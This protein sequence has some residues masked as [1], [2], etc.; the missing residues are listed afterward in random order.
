VLSVNS[1][2][3]DYIDQCRR[4]VD[5]EVAAYEAL[6]SASGK[7]GAAAKRVQ[8]AVADFEPKF[9]NSMVLVLDALVVHR[10]RT[11]EGKDGN[12]L[13]EVR[14]LCRSIMENGGVLMADKQIKLKADASVLKLEVGDEISLTAS[15][16]RLICDAYFAELEAR[17]L[18]A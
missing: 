9:F 13:N 4:L 12:P 11:L 18:E 5:E 10:A 14:M 3:R 8:S 2:S 1:Y 6:I 15:D 17:F 16:F 7:S